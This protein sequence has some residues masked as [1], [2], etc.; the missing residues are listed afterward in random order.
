MSRTVL[1]NKADQLAR[2]GTGL[3]FCGTEQ[4]LSCKYPKWIL[5]EH[6]SDQ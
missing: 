3:Q 2:D 4:S 6:D 1:K 5:K